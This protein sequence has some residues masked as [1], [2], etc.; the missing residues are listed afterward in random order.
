MAA[1]CQ[2]SSVYLQTSFAWTDRS[3][4][5]TAG[6]SWLDSSQPDNAHGATQN[7]VILFAAHSITNYKKVN[8]FPGA[9]DDVSCSVASFDKTGARVVRGYVCG[10]PA[11]R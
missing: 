6:F 3:T 7:C 9:L 11:R 5:G 1:T 4:T 2:N 8:W 10:Q